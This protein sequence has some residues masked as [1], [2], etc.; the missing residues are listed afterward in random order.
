M[1]SK[2]SFET[3]FE[4]AKAYME[5]EYVEVGPPLKKS[6]YDGAWS[7]L[8][9][10]ED[11]FRMKPHRRHVP[12]LA[13]PLS[14]IEFVR[15]FM[16]TSTAVRIPSHLV[17]DMG[18][19]V[20]TWTLRELEQRFP[21][22]GDWEAARFHHNRANDEEASLGNMGAAVQVLKQLENVSRVQPHPTYA[23][24]IAEHKVES[25]QTRY[26]H[27]MRVRLD[28]LDKVGIESPPPLLEPH[29][30]QLPTLWMVSVMWTGTGRVGLG[31]FSGRF[32]DFYGV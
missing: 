28:H 13:V 18:W 15:L 5:A 21:F 30:F 2:L 9:L 7:Q 31:R 20:Q 1:R 6:R 3:V 23:Q 19:K 32:S 16:M 10:H 26:I 12:T 11:Y 29:R 17:Q 14:P 27:N 8:Q 22:D 24:A 4:D 25:G